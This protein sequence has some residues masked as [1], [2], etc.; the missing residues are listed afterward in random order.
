MSTTILKITGSL[1]NEMTGGAI[2]ILDSKID[3][4]HLYGWALLLK[5]GT[6]TR[7]SAPRETIKKGLENCLS[8][9]LERREVGKLFCVS[10]RAASR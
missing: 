10:R 2:C 7:P 8:F 9:L 1:T 3:L 5:G 6:F 4:V